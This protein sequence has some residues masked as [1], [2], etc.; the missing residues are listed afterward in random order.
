[1]IDVDMRKSTSFFLGMLFRMFNIGITYVYRCGEAS[2]D[3]FK[4]IECH[5]RFAHGVF[6]AEFAFL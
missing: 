3:S 6:W 4:A 1:M 2:F 5:L